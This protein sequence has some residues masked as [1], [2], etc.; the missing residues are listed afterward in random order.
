VASLDPSNVTMNSALKTVTPAG[1][2]PV[3]ALR[4]PPD[5]SILP[6]PETPPTT[7]PITTPPATKIAT[8][9]LVIIKDELLP[10][11]TMTDLVFENIGGHELINVSRHDLVNGIDVLY[12][13]I[14]N[15]STLYLQYNPEN[16]LRLQ[17]TTQSYFKN[18]PIQYSNKIPN[19]GTGPN[20]ETVYIEAGTG[21][22]IINVINLAKGE[23][24]EVQVLAQGDVFDDTIYGGV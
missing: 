20:G 1:T 8:P 4:P 6:V 10:V 24:A 19:V 18:F 23:Q 11:D 3:T 17:D 12:Q 7:N 5:V 13:P 2:A 9:D 22:L 14:K 15:L 21:D 16:I